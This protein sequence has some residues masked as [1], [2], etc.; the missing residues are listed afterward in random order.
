M[1]KP[2][3]QLFFAL[4]NSLLLVA[5]GGG[6][7]NGGDN[8]NSSTEAVVF[9]LNNALF[10]ST[11]K[12][13]TPIALSP[14]SNTAGRVAQY[15]LS[16]DKK[17]VAYLADAETDQLYEL[18]VSSLDGTNVGKKLSAAATD[19]GRSI[20]NIVWSPDSTQLAYVSDQ[21]I[22]LTWEL[23]VSTI[24]GTIG[25]KVSADPQTG[26]EGNTD[27]IRRG[28]TVAPLSS[29][30]VQWA[31]DGSRLAYIADWDTNQV[32]ELH[33][34][35][36]DGNANVV[37]IS[38]PM[39]ASAGN[40]GD[41]PWADKR[42]SF[43]WAPDS[44]RIAYRADQEVDGIFHLYVAEPAV[45]TS[46]VKV[47]PNVSDGRV[48]AFEWAPDSSRLA[49]A[50]SEPTSGDTRLFRHLLGSTVSTIPLSPE[51][52]PGQFGT[53]DIPYFSWAPDSSRIAYVADLRIN[54]RYELFTISPDST[55]SNIRVSGGDNNYDGLEPNGSAAF[56]WSPDSQYIAYLSYQQYENRREL[57]ASTANGDSNVK[58][59]GSL[60]SSKGIEI[61][62]W[63]PDSSHV[64]YVANQ[65]NASYGELFASPIAGAR[66]TSDA[67]G[68]GPASNPRLNPDLVQ[69][70]E[71]S[72]TFLQ[73]S[74]DSQRVMYY[75]DQDAD[76]AVAFY[77]STRDGNSNNI[78]ISRFS[79]ATEI[80]PRMGACDACHESINSSET[81][82]FYWYKDI[83]SDTY[84]AMNTAGH[85]N[86]NYIV[87]KLDGTRSHNA[88]GITYY[89][90]A[91]MFSIWMSEGA[92]N[93]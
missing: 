31:P 13:G 53:G 56:Y 43:A 36:P 47:S 30:V 76:G 25:V 22:I 37:K 67:D 49:Y 7:G 70:G 87:E 68:G 14:M 28:S 42:R 9:Q 63:S 12:G 44:S 80:Y 89:P 86:N 73:W 88:G 58:L 5:C 66:E 8:N 1:I 50:Y 78:K 57:F 38:G 61:Y 35:T 2:G 48:Q 71:V 72:G 41:I 46:P 40:G 4:L 29:D 3:V 74:A 60:S 6:G 19:S 21:E 92:N 17:W 54:E 26:R 34:T 45:Q 32:F 90:L 18:Y 55:L 79:F 82:D 52:G 24:N 16:P 59:S 91:S 27:V 11:P 10:A 81:G 85:F 15:V 64:A 77:S 75:A 62:Q 51:T 83:A 65:N 93:N 23:Y 69:D 20:D 33:T 84:D 39:V